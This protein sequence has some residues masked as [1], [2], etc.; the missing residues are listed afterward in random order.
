MKYHSK[1]EIRD[2]V[3]YLI[4]IIGTWLIGKFILTSNVH[5]LI[6]FLVIM[7]VTALSY[8]IYPKH[9]QPTRVDGVRL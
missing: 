2:F 6:Q 8:L 5:W 4:M 1:N 9:L 3:I 7:L